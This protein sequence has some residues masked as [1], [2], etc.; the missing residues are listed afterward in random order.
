MWKDERTQT[1]KE[2]I[3][4][5]AYC[6]TFDV[7]LTSSFFQNLGIHRYSRERKEEMEKTVIE[8]SLMEGWKDKKEQNWRLKQKKNTDHYSKNEEIS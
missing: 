5:Q 7:K 2:T 4:E 1:N 8:L 6:F 3:T